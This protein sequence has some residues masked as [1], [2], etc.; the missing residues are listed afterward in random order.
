[1]ATKGASFLFVRPAATPL[2]R[3]REFCQIISAQ[4]VGAARWNSIAT[5]CHV[6]PFCLREL[7]FIELNVCCPYGRSKQ[8]KSKEHIEEDD[9][10]TLRCLNH[11]KSLCLTNSSFLHTT[12]LRQSFLFK[13]SKLTKQTLMLNPYVQHK[14]EENNNSGQVDWVNQRPAGLTI[15]GLLKRL[16]HI[17]AR[18]TIIESCSRYRS[19]FRSRCETSSKGLLKLELNNAPSETPSGS[20][21]DR[22]SP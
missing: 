15:P 7:H 16:N 1:M 22:V 19:R 8:L 21:H 2:Y 4:Q 14:V 11:L 10:S 17:N 12:T 5:I 13:Q 9:L 20:R 3:K 18:Y 6:T